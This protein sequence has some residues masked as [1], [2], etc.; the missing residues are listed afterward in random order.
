MTFKGKRP[1]SALQAILESLEAI[2]EAYKIEGVG[3]VLRNLY[4]LILLY[5]EI[6]CIII[7]LNSPWDLETNELKL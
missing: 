6:D 2:L 7:S 3:G 1:S 5:V 4:T